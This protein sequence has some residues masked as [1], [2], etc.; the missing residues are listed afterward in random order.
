MKPVIAFIT[1]F[2]CTALMAQEN[3]LNIAKFKFNLQLSKIIDYMPIKNLTAALEITC[4]V[5][6]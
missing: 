4:G 6:Q 2:C 5:V 1:C 3:V